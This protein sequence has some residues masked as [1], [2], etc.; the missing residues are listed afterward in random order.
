MNENRVKKD[1]VQREV[2]NFFDE[3]KKKSIGK[4]A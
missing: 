4:S 1:K 3:A 2:D